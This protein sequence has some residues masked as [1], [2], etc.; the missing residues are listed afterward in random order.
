M[1]FR[2]FGSGLLLPE[3]LGAG[4]SSWSVGPRVVTFLRLK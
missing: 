3:E 1:G 4:I 2:V